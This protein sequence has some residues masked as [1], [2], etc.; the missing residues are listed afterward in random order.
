[1]TKKNLSIAIGADHAGFEY[2]QILQE[3]L[4][5][6]EVKDFGTYSADSVDYPDF[7]H[8]VASAVE[9]KQFDLGILICGSANGVAITANK[10]A[11]VR[12]AL[13]WSEEVAKLARQHNNANVVCIP[14]RFVSEETAKQI[15]QAFIDTDFEGGRHA[16][17]V[18]K[19]SC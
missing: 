16:N 15:T 18:S 13:C 6:F 9:D 19:I 5:D 17:R 7:A 14:A 2:K 1:M 3:Y 11:G 4:K 8:P 12:A 10:H